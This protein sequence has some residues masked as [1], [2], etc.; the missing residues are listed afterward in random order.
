MA[1]I[2]AVSPLQLIDADEWRRRHETLPE[3]VRLLHV[4]A[5]EDGRAVGEALASYGFFTGADNGFFQVRVHPDYRRQGIGTALYARVV[6]H[7]DELGVKEVLTLFDENEPGNAFA[8]LYGFEEVRAEMWSIVDPRTVDEAPDPSVELIPARD[9]DPRDFHRVGEETSRDVPAHADIEEITYEDWRAFI[10]DHP[11]FTQ[12]GSFGAI[13]DGEL[14][15][16]TIVFADMASGRATNMFTGTRATVRGRGLA[17]A[18]KLASIRWAA[19]NGITQIAATNDETNAPML[20]V[21][22]RLG[23]RPAIRRVEWLAPRERFLR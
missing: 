1:L 3:R 16:Q 11:F 10:W 8:R 23:F 5:D 17:R 20:A 14:A 15:A 21:N 6:D 19:E 4:V 12:D 18:A 22:R 2:R 9:I 7:L 13:V